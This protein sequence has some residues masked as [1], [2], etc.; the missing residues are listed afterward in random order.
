MLHPQDGEHLPITGSAESP[1][2]QMILPLILQTILIY[3]WYWYWPIIQMILS[4]D[5]W[6]NTNL[7]P[8]PC[9]HRPPLGLNC[10]EALIMSNV[11]HRGPCIFS[12]LI[13]PVKGRLPECH[14]NSLMFELSSGVAG[15]L[16]HLMISCGFSKLWFYKVQAMAGKPD[17]LH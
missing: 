3:L 16:K 8:T 17:I 4:S 9:R 2:I 12:K 15:T 11:S 10:H 14:F 5:I 13:F 1:P 7:S 6:N